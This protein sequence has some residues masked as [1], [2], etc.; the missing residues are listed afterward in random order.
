[1]ELSDY[2]LMFVY[3]KGS[4][5]ILAGGISR[6][7]TQ[8]IYRDPLENPKTSK[9]MNCI[10]EYKN[11]FNPVMFSPDGLLQKQQYVH[12]LKYIIVAPYSIIPIT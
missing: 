3:I 10:A 11:S 6:L 5:N 12:G 4:K 7:M 1:M 9:T 2:N 8:D